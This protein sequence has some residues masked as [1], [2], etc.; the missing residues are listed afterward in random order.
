MSVFR[1]AKDRRV[2]FEATPEGQQKALKRRK[3]LRVGLML[4]LIALGLFAALCVVIILNNH[5]H[6]WITQ[7]WSEEA[8]S[9]MASVR[10][11]LP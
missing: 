9:S 6:W 8:V 2:A 10:K 4:F 1:L 11:A 5:F 7:P 3:R